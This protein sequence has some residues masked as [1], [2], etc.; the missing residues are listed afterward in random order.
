MWLSYIPNHLKLSRV[1]GGFP[2]AID[3]SSPKR[4]DADSRLRLAMPTVLFVVFSGLQVQMVLELS[5]KFGMGLDSV[6]TIALLFGISTLDVVILMATGSWAFLCYLVG[7]ATFVVKRRSICQLYADISASGIRTQ[8]KE[9]NLVLLTLALEV[10]MVVLGSCLFSAAVLCLYQK[11]AS[12]GTVTYQDWLFAVS[13]GAANLL[14]ITNPMFQSMIELSWD[15]LLAMTEAFLRWT[16]SSGNLVAGRKHF[17]N[18][19][20]SHVNLGR[21][22]CVL[23]EQVEDTLAP[24]FLFDYVYFLIAG[25]AYTFGGFDILYNGSKSSTSAILLECGFFLYASACFYLLW[26]VSHVGDG[27]KRAKERAKQALEDCYVEVCHALDEKEKLE[28]NILLGRIDSVKIAPYNYFEVANSHLMGVV[29]AVV[30]YI[31][32]MLQFNAL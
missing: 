26:L 19:L 6:R 23:V 13:Y 17:R 2:L 25:V 32:V 16:A 30:T 20:A 12:D 31:I 21:R 4:V 10:V 9:K 3:P 28:V 24:F 14:Y 22:L 18:R 27:L 11:V 1:L 7:F 8:R 5:R 15:V 29:A